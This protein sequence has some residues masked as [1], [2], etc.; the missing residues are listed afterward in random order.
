MYIKSPC[1]IHVE[2]HIEASL[3]RICLTY[4]WIRTPFDGA[5]ELLASDEERKDVNVEVKVHWWRAYLNDL[6][7]I[8][9]ELESS[10]DEICHS[11]RIDRDSWANPFRIF[12]DN[13]AKLF[14][15]W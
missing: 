12:L 4:R 11:S 13:I 7:T 1:E 8:A 14:A 3:L 10:L 15:F 6:A 5:H 9:S 2:S